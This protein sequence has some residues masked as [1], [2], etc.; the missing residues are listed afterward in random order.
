MDFWAHQADA[1]QRSRWLVVLFAAAVLLIVIAVNAV[2]LTLFALFDSGEL[3]DTAWMARHPRAVAVTTL[4]VL[5]VVGIANLYRTM[6]LSA[7]G[8]VVARSLGGVRV[9]A[10]T[11]EPLRRRL[12]NVVE[13][14]AIAVG[15]PV[16]SVYVLEQ[17]DGINAFAAGHTAANAA[18]AVTRGALEQLDRAELQGVIGHEFSHVL[19]GDMRLNIRLMGLLFGLLVIAIAGRTVTWHAPRRI[20]GR[21]G[22][23]AGLLVLAGFAIMLLGYI[24]VFFGRLIQAAVSR[25]REF[26]AD[27][28]AVQFTRD[29]GGL[30]D[31]L[32]KIGSQQ[33]SRLRH[34]DTDEVAHMLFAPGM[35]RWFATH[36]PLAE[37]IRALDPSFDPAA[38]D[39]LRLEVTPQ[40][41]GVVQ[42][43]ARDRVPDSFADPQVLSR[44]YLRLDPQSVP[45]R[46]ANPGVAEVRR[47]AELRETLRAGQWTPV[48]GSARAAAR[49]LGLV[50]YPTTEIRDLQLAKIRIRLGADMAGLV[51]EE[52]AQTDRLRPDERLP[53][54][55][56]LVAPLRELSPGKRHAI[57][58]C[59]AESCRVDGAIA[60]FEYALTTLARVYLEE[61]LD[62]RRRPAAVTLA[63]ATTEL[64]TLFS[65][66]AAHGHADEAARERAYRTGIALLQP[67]PALPA[68]RFVP[69]W[70]NALDRALRCLDGLA[71]A[72][73][74]Q[75][76]A[77]LA[78][79]IVHDG[80]V[81]IEE[82]E[83]LRVVCAV[84]HCPL[85]PL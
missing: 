41:L 64:Q 69:G 78:A 53:V 11:T 22:E 20:S 52:A 21:R 67:Q 16:P 73:K 30:C 42:V 79:T 70:A 39:D 34:P 3:A 50:L 27:A 55:A 46:V 81:T 2:V 9:S 57:L 71:P 37:R 14:M 84:L 54:L 58:E 28:S 10:E 62:P 29:T 13:E 56:G 72:Q 38:F 15:V 5:A 48:P 25:Q 35:T 66:I 23:G 65:T 45:G 32:I 40:P 60:I 6:S 80:E 17:E 76:V 31:A 63:G 43:A 77:A 1:R 74:R 59:L 18:I 8:G 19:N 36:P 85:P 83:L 47:A 4:V 49:L 44:Q 7:G 51:A 82:G 24:G 26:L 68:Y 61:T 33:G 75:L 12:L